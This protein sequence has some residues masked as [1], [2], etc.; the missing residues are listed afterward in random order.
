MDIAFTER[1]LDVMD[2]LWERGATLAAA[3][4]ALASVAGALVAIFSGL[5]VVRAI[6]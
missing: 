5:A 4:Y 1:E 6:G 3:G 2:V